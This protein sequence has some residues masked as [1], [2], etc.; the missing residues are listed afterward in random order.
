M[1]WAMGQDDDGRLISQTHGPGSI[2]K[3]RQRQ[4]DREG[5]MEKEAE[6]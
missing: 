2:I 5:E 4:R 3:V 6:R 1:R